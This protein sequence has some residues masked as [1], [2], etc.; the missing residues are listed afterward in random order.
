MVTVCLQL[1]YSCV[2]GDVLWQNCPEINLIT[3][4]GTFV[5]KI[6]HYLGKLPIHEKA[7]SHTRNQTLKITQA[8]TGRKNV[9]FRVKW[10]QVL[11]K[12]LWYSIITEHNILRFQILG[13]W[14]L[15]MI[16]NS[17]CQRC[18]MPC[19]ADNN[20]WHRKL[21]KGIPLRGCQPRSQQKKWSSVSKMQRVQ[22]SSSWSIKKEKQKTQLE[23]VKPLYND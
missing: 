2:T 7:S 10:W 14:L 4:L 23:K 18:T 19:I 22:P 11:H 21:T 12:D 20:W 6:A 8:S 1:C 17:C 5:D 13:S 3:R 9:P 16:Q 15:H